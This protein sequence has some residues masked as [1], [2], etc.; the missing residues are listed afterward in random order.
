MG[1]AADW[2]WVAFATVFY[3]GGMLLWETIRRTNRSVEPALLPRDVLTW[4]LGGLAFGLITTFHWEAFH[5]PLIL[6]TLAAFAI[7]AVV[8]RWA[9]R[10]PRSQG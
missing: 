1:T 7:G 4:T 9:K 3:G 2:M 10:T 5:W 8:A 6:L